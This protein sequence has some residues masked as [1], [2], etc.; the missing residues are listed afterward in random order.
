MTNRRWN[1]ITIPL[2]HLPLR[3]LDEQIERAFEELLTTPWLA[4][5]RGWMPQLDVFETPDD[6]LIEADLPGVAL[7][8]LQV[9]VDGC[10]VT[11]CG[12]RSDGR[13]ETAQGIIRV[14]R[15]HGSFCRRVILGQP[16]SGEGIQITQEHGVFRI[17]VPKQRDQ[18]HT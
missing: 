12:S 5:P 18:E 17:R 11:I 14:E 3:R 2:S 8:E 16:V 13:T 7:G 10:S 6:F 15:R 9:E 1:P 4:E